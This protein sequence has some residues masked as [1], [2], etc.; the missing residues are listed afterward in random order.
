MTV[1]ER[2]KVEALSMRLFP[3]D[4]HKGNCRKEIGREGKTCRICDD[5]NKAWNDRLWQVYNALTAEELI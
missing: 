4:F 5:R 1:D 2:K 3:D